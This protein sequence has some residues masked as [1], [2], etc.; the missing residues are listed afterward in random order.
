MISSGVPLVRGWAGDG[1]GSSVGLNGIYL[2]KRDGTGA[3]T[4]SVRLDSLCP[5]LKNDGMKPRWSQLDAYILVHKFVFVVS[6]Y[7]IIY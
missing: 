7:T 4:L 3:D 2:Y 6:I 1:G 5:K